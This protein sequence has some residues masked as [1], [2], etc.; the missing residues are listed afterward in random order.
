MK[1]ER[2]CGSGERRW[3]IVV[4]VMGFACCIER[5]DEERI[6]CA[7][8]VVVYNVPRVEASKRMRLYSSIEYQG[9]RSV[10]G[11]SNRMYAVS[12]RK[13]ILPKHHTHAK[14]KQSVINE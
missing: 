14:R 13:P 10:T 2:D 7:F 11:T 5:R 9:H 6:I 8:R 4:K 12:G 1:R 3:R